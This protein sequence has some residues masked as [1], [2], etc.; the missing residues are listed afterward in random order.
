MSIT[1]RDFLRL[2]LLS[3]G[4]LA[5]KP[6][7]MKFVEAGEW[8][9]F[10]KLGR[11]N[12]GKVNI[13]T[14]PSA[15]APSA[16]VLYQDA[17]IERLREVVGEVPTGL[18]GGRWVE[19]PKG[20]IYAPSVQ[21]VK[22]L[23][24]KIEND[25][26]TNPSGKGMWAEV[27]VPYVDLFL[28]NPPARSPWL[29]AVSQPRL[30]Y[31]QVMWIDD[32]QTNSKGQVLYHVNERYGSYGDTFWAAGEAF[33]RITEDEISPIHPDVQ[34]KKV[35]VDLNRQTLSCLEGNT[36]VYFCR[37][38]SGAKF[39]A[40]GNAVDAWST[41]VGPH[42]LWRKLISVHMSGGTTGNGWDTV[43]IAWTTFFASQGQAIHSTFWHNNFGVPVSHGCVNAEPEDAKWV[44][45]W[46]SPKVAYDPGDI[47]VQMPGGT[48]VDIQE[49]TLP[50]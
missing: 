11:I 7:Q 15:D 44:F 45:R 37:I 38:S 22:N 23:P 46:T 6:W 33:R 48:I 21:P 25:L 5:F 9:D 26:P 47:T 14:Y 19:T 31:S 17:V 35:V 39:D 24:N 20:Y 42:P 18:I 32:I 36:E 49:Q 13:R 4:T 8:P 40:Y 34:D 27:T 41:P 3:A 10:E 2:S 29:K 43:G 1:R 50:Q 16:G 12:V 30:Y 28:D